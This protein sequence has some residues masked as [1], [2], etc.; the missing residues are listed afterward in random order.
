MAGSNS[1]VNNIELWE[2]VLPETPRESKAKKPKK[3]PPKKKEILLEEALPKSSHDVAL[4]L[5]QA[6]QKLAVEDGQR[7]SEA[8]RF[9]DVCMT[10]VQ[11]YQLLSFS[12]IGI[13]NITCVLPLSTVREVMYLETIKDEDSK[14]VDNDKPGPNDRDPPPIEATIKREKSTEG[15]PVLMA[16]KN[17]QLSIVVGE[18]NEPMDKLH[19]ELKRR[20]F[21][22]QPSLDAIKTKHDK[23]KLSIPSTPL[24]TYESKYLFVGTRDGFGHILVLSELESIAPSAME[25]KPEEEQ[26][27]EQQ[28]VQPSKK[29]TDEEKAI[30]QAREEEAKK[31][32]DI[33]SMVKS[34]SKY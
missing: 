19:D 26:Q 14:K 29:L 17:N 1:T 3:L 34:V 11:K 15:I 25:T 23:L 12:D 27:E 9:S 21:Q 22:S 24:A 20:V 30:E 13:K 18:F 16:S 32:D 2:R 33:V 28:G 31:I 8:I 4:R 5:S 6:M 7:L 10:D